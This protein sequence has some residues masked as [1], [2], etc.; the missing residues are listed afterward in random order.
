MVYAIDECVLIVCLF[1]VVF[2][3]NGLDFLTSSIDE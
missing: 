2:A 3:R 1:G